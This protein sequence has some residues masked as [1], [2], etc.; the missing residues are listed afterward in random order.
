MTLHFSS[1]IFGISGRLHHGSARTKRSPQSESDFKEVIWTFQPQTQNDLVDTKRN[2]F[3][4]SPCCWFFPCCVYLTLFTACPKAIHGANM[5]SSQ[6]NNYFLLK[7]G[8]TTSSSLQHIR[9]KSNGTT[10][11]LFAGLHLHITLSMKSIHSTSPPLET[12]WLMVCEFSNVI[13]RQQLEV[14]GGGNGHRDNYPTCKNGLWVTPQM[15]RN[16]L[17]GEGSN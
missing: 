11:I 3:Q 16:K 17:H 13:K 1:C 15:E 10:C 7:D 4:M 8:S 9:I 2:S 14:C 12:F 5:W 6:Q